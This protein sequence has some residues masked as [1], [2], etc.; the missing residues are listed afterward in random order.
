MRQFRGMK[1]ILLSM[2]NGLPYIGNVM[3]VFLFL[4]VVFAIMGVEGLGGLFRRRCVDI[5]TGSLFEPPSPEPELFCNFDDQQ[6][7]GLSCPAIGLARR[8][9]LDSIGADGTSHFYPA[10]PAAQLATLPA[11]NLTCKELSTNPNFG[12]THFDLITNSMYTVFQIG[13]M[14]DWHVLSYWMSGA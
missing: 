14:E 2:W 8:E 9:L 7:G 5:S 10:M 11:L 13:A 12:I 4:V 1:V 3:V 6:K